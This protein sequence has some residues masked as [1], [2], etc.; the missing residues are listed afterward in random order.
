MSSNYM[1]LDDSI[2]DKMRIDLAGLLH[3]V[4]RGKEGRELLE[5]C[6]MITERYKDLGKDSGPDEQSISFPMLHLAV[7][8]Y[9]LKRDE[10]A[11]QL[12]LEALRIRE[13]AFGKGL[14]SRCGG[15]RLFG[16]IQTRLTKDDESL[17]GPLK[18]VLSIHEKEFGPESEEVTI[19]LKKIVFYLDKLGRKNNVFPLQNRLSALRL[20]FKQRIQL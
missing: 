6:L 12:A 16:V 20:K 4:G 18:R 3:A 14:P 17:L 15:S 5:E 9:H 10:E 2:M 7:T 11:E 1:A 8:L 13:K 19:T